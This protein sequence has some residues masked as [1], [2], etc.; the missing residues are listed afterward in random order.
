MIYHS[1]IYREKSG[2][3]P[4]R[5]SGLWCI[6]TI[7]TLDGIQGKSAYNYTITISYLQVL[8]SGH[9]P[10]PDSAP[11]SRVQ[12]WMPSFSKRYV[13]LFYGSYYPSSS[14]LFF[15]DL[16]HVIPLFKKPI[17]VYLWCRYRIYK[18][19]HLSCSFLW[20]HILTPLSSLGP[21]TLGPAKDAMGIR[22]GPWDF[23][24]TGDSPTN[25]PGSGKSHNYTTNLCIIDTNR[26]IHLFI[27]INNINIGIDI[28]MEI[29]R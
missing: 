3:E 17:V 6:Y 2:Y 19:H 7:P 10:S 13:V 24:K 14:C 12:F 18:N 15:F 9:Y 26:T 16:Y 20:S 1:A 27:V 28:D 11:V 23:W 25:W 8:T 22:W 4:A 5:T 21:R 29:W